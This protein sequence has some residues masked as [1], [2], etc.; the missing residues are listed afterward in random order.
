[1]RLILIAA[2][3]LMVV[4]CGRTNIS[5]GSDTN[6]PCTS[7]ISHDGI[8][9]KLKSKYYDCPGYGEVIINIGM[10]KN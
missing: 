6:S 1:M 2:L 4:S 10:E 5:L 8:E 9:C 3:S 7:V